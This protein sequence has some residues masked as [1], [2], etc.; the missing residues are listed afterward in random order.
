MPLPTLE[1]TSTA[2]L[3]MK[4]A[5]F[6]VVMQRADRDLAALSQLSDSNEFLRHSSFV[7]AGC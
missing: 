6:V 1:I 2:Q 5:D 7:R 4:Q 3:R